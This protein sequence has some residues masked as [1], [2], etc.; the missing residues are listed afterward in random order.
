MKTR[1]TI[2][3][4]S[5]YE[6]AFRDSGL[7]AA[8]DAAIDVE[9]GLPAGPIR[10]TLKQ[11]GQDSAKSQGIHKDHANAIIDE[12][13]ASFDEQVA[14]IKTKKEPNTDAVPYRALG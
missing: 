14:S 13:L 1:A 5:R 2:H 10:A 4:C 7:L 9:M 8:T 3:R 11:A 12:I 6:E